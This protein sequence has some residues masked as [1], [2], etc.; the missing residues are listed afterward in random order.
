MPKDSIDRMVDEWAASDGGRDVS[1][2]QVVGRL[3]RSAGH[4]QAAVVDALRP[5]GLSYGDFDVLNTLR[6]RD[7]PGGTHPRDLAETALITSGAMTARLDR[8]ER[9]G[10]VK[11]RPDPEDRRAVRIRL[12]KAGA[13]LAAKALDAVLVADEAMLAPLTPAQRRT[14]A[15][16]LKKMLLHAEAS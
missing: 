2:L 6:R 9:S 12:T 10:L 4:G 1:A 8:L 16:L 7:D 13:N 15:A 11:R 3:F 14:L 5:F